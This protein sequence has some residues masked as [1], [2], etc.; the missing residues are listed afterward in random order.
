MIVTCTCSNPGEGLFGKN[1]M[2]CSNGEIRSCSQNQECYA[3]KAFV[4]GQ[5]SNGCR[6]PGDFLDW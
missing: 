1:E 3:T 2:R 5:W 6:V 4:Y